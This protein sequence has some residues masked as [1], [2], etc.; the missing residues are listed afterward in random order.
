MKKVSTVLSMLLVFSGLYAAGENDNTIIVNKSGIP[1][2]VTFVIKRIS[3]QRSEEILL[4]V[5]ISSFGKVAIPYN[6]SINDI[7]VQVTDEVG[8]RYGLKPKAA[9]KFRGKSPYQFLFPDDFASITTD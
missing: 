9:Q 4:P 5:N 7:S 2:K 1:I 3:T 6:A 8:E